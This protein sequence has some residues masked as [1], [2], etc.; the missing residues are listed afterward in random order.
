MIKILTL[1]VTG[2]VLCLVVAYSYEFYRSPVVSVKDSSR[3][4]SLLTLLTILFTLNLTNELAIVS[5]IALVALYA[6]FNVS[7]LSSAPNRKIYDFSDY[8]PWA[9][10]SSSASAN[11]VWG[12][13]TSLL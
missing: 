12:W 4:S 3:F 5:D 13:M 2:T 10:P 9:S 11:G 8:H 6:I 7:M 1:L